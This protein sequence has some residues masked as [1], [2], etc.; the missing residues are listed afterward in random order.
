MAADTDIHDI[1]L[2][3]YKESRETESLTTLS[4][5]GS[6]KSS[7]FTKYLPAW[8]VRNKSLFAFVASV[9]WG[10]TSNTA[11]TLYDVISDYMLASKHLR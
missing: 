7:T 4:I 2:Q 8:L 10:L 3:S 5:E 6:T 9:L 11:L 1:E